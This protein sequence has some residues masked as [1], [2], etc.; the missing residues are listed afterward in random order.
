MSNS[1]LPALQRL[2]E[3]VARLR[4]PDG[5]CPWD[6]AQTPQSLIPYVIEE[7]YET[8][9][10]LQT[11]TTADVCEELG[12][13]LLQVMLQAQI[14]SEQAQFTLAD[15]ADGISEK[16][17][18]RHP[19]VFGEDTAD[20]VEAVRH[21]WEQ[22]KAQEK[23]NAPVR[24][25]DGF[26]RYAH[27]LPPL[28]ASLK[29]SKKAA[30]FG[31]EWDRIE[32]VWGKVEEEWQEL[33]AAIASG[34]KAHQEAELGDLF[35]ALIQIARWQGLDPS[36]ALQGTNHRFIQRLRIMEDNADRP[37]TDYDLAALD[38]LW[39]QAKRQLGQGSPKPED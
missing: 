21:N 13:L 31:F 34:D 17:I 39:N 12:D 26:Q 28:M 11:G 3:V 24:M 20:T 6:L 4:D 19:H 23:G 37:L 1:A 9:A 35:F 25:S 36:Q 30:A 38:A 5:G 27:G 32:D 8:V 15:V 22:I 29:I 7:A 14:A 33:Q 16:L 10:A 2:I 18:R